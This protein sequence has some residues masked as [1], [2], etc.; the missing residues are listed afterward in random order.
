MTGKV[1]RGRV[2]ILVTR[3]VSHNLLCASIVNERKH[4][5]KMITSKWKK[6][7]EGLFKADAQKVGEEL[8]GIKEATGTLF[9]EQIVDY[10]RDESSELHKCFDWDDAS[11]AEKYRKAQARQIVCCIVIAEATVPEDRP[12]IRLLY[13]P[14]GSKTGYEE[15][16]K[17]VRNEDAYKAL[18]QT[19]WA[20][21]KAFKAKYSML[22]ELSEIF[23]LIK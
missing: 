2:H 18:L 5:V 9:P 22:K 4:I 1:S 15:T 13:K 21:L 23:E 11:A 3:V 10:A 6:G 17:I 12:E 7:C 19:A 14:N 8:T 16:R 20:E